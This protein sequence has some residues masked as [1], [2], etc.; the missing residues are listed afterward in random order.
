M[1]KLPSNV[2]CYGRTPEFNDK[3]IPSGLQSSHRTKPGT[4]AKI[5]V[6]EGKLTYRILERDVS[7]VELTPKAPGIVE[8]EVLHMVKPV[9]KVRFFIEFYR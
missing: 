6:V 5:V 4:W 1:N 9:D 2:A 7:E 3:T 8:P